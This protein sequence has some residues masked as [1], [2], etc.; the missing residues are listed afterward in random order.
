MLDC[1]II[2]A[3]PSGIVAAK[4]LL[5][6]GISNIICL[7]QSSEIGG[8]FSHTYDNLKLT[9]S[10]T[11]SMFSDFWI[12]DDEINKFWTKEEAVDYWSR[13]ADNFGVKKYIQFGSNVDRIDNIGAAQYGENGWEVYLDS[14]KKY[15]CHRLV[16]AIGNNRIPKY[17]KWKTSLKDVDC[18]HSISF[19]NASPFK[20]KRVLVVGGGESG[21]DVALEVSKV[22]KKCWISL[23]SSTGWVVPRK[24]G[25]FATDN[26]THRS[27]WNLP[28]SHGPLLAKRI[29][30]S[31]QSLKDPIF[32]TVVKLN[33]LVDT[34]YG[35]RGSYGTKTLA[36]PKAIVD[37]G[38]EVVQDISTVKTQEKRLLTSDGKI[39]EDVDAV[40]FCTG[41][42]NLIPML[43]KHL[44]QMDPRSMYKHM[45]NPITGD[46]LFIIGWA[47]PGFGSQFPISEMQARFLSLI[48][49]KKHQLPSSTKMEM[50]ASQDKTHY[51][52]RFQEN[53]HRI[54]SLVDY[55]YYMDNL[56]SII[57]C[58]PPLKKYFFKNPKLWAKMFFG[59]TQG[60]QFRLKGPG[61]KKEKAHEILRKLPKIKLNVIIKE[62]IKGRIKYAFKRFFL[63]PFRRRAL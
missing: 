22:A 42:Q 21:S 62:G 54:R 9:S 32:D 38:C 48:I 20:D 55:H 4:E 6:Q 51:L 56:A 13:Y 43:P 23:R 60:T 61:E 11:F 53:A 3:G 36:L 41:Y 2:G 27:V 47:R 31:D 25:V 63:G 37:Y 7:E 29:I 19:K 50:I 1:I 40:I 26:S 59:P 58:S 8:T 46:K 45:V 52:D 34:K 30:K 12:G 44:Q 16:F 39:L 18:S 33:K 35:I 5:E 28:I 24:R 15:S 17:P 57:G 14:N 49:A 10:T